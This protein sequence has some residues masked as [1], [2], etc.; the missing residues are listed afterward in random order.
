MDALL[1]R[2]FAATEF[3][4]TPQGVLVEGVAVPYGREADIGGMFRERFEAGA[5]GD[6]SNADVIANRQHDRGQP[7]AR[8][9]PGGGLTLQ[10][11]PD[12]LRASVLLPPTADGKDT[13]ELLKRG[14]LRGFSVEFLI[15][16]GGETWVDTLRSI[17][18]AELRGLAIVDRPAY[19]DAEAKV[20]ERAARPPQTPPVAPRRRVVI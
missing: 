1:E 5:F 6:L 10:D 7:L 15:A 20:A 8:T 3:R 2:R 12:A 18:R 9:G 19:T 16:E 11:G 13:G 14:V 17:S 4:E